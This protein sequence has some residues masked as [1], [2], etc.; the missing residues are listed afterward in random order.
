MSATFLCIIKS[1]YSK[2]YTKLCKIIKNF[3]YLDCNV[4][5]IKSANLK[6][7][8][9]T[10]ILIKIYSDSEIAKMFKFPIKLS[11]SLLNP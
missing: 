8:K 7:I 3:I 1:L 6:R 9:K 11:E 5:L 4:T 2:L 10:E